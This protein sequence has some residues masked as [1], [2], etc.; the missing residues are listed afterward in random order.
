MPVK[1]VPVK[2]PEV[3]SEAERILRGESKDEDRLP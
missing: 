2:Q 3:L 1:T